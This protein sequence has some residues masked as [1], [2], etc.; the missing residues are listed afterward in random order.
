M[1]FFKHDDSIKNV[2]YKTNSLEETY[3][4]ARKFVTGELP[5]SCQKKQ[6]ATVVGLF[7]NLGA[8]KTSF[9][10]GIAKAYGI[11]DHIT[12]PTFVLEKIYKLGKKL[13][14][15]HLVHID[16]YRLEGGKE[17]SALGW[18]E[19]IKNPKNIIFIEWPERVEEVLPRD[20]IKIYFETGEKENERKIKILC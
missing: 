11:K 20:I 6:G 15:E 10:Q 14:Y 9:T 18:D 4:L 3:E 12:S 2:E 7:G 1:D 19:I 5:C 13:D 16:A 17:M 8:G